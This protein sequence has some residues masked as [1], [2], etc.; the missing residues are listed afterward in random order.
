MF[1]LIW[2]AWAAPVFGA[3]AHDCI[4]RWR[5]GPLGA[6]AFSN[7]AIEKWG[8]DFQV[9]AALDLEQRVL[10]VCESPVLRDRLEAIQRAYLKRL[11]WTTPHPQPGLLFKG[12]LNTEDETTAVQERLAKIPATARNESALNVLARVYGDAALV[13]GVLVVGAKP[14]PVRAI[15]ALAQKAC[16]RMQPCGLWDP[17]FLGRVALLP[18]GGFASYVPELASLRLSRELLDKHSSLHTLV[19][20]HELAHAA[21]WRARQKLGE[22]WRP[23][24]AKFS[25]WEKKDGALENPVRPAPGKWRDELAVQS[26]GSSYSLLPDPPMPAFTRKEMPV[27]GFVFARSDRETRKSSDV[28]EDLADHVAAY[29]VAPH[30]FCFEGKPVAPRKYAW[31]AKYVFAQDLKLN[32]K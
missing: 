4:A 9:S 1:I 2:L 5:S 25:H 30:R 31:V 29:V 6:A 21:E 18:T 20:V 8:A 28:G 10:S 13:N 26:E 7:P 3:P 32:C 19:M 22:E 27:D 16:G 11:G 17:A 23:V 24:F 12:L 15:E 14:L